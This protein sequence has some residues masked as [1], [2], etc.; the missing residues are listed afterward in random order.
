MINKEWVDIENLSAI[1][2]DKYVANLQKYVSGRK[3]H[4]FGTVTPS[5]DW[6]ELAQV[7]FNHSERIHELGVAITS[8]ELDRETNPSG[9]PETES[10]RALFF[11]ERF[12]YKET[13][14]L[15]SDILRHR[16][17]Q[18][19]SFVGFKPAIPEVNRMLKSLGIK[20]GWMTDVPKCELTLIDVIGKVMEGKL[21]LTPEAFRVTPQKDR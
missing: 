17:Y 16:M 15:L 20:G 2:T 3:V 10:Y 21:K 11:Q 7:F 13:Q 12:H 9:I 8:A 18:S 14:Y 19:R 4:R 1:M 5:Q 6:V